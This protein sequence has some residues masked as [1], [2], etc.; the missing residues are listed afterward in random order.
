MRGGGARA[1]T[2][3]APRSP[4][5]CRAVR[6]GRRDI[7]EGP[8]LDIQFIRSQPD[9]VRGAIKNKGFDL[10]LDALL[11]IDKQRRET[12]TLLEQ[13]RARKNELSSVIP[14]AGKDERPKLVEEA[15]QI[16]TD[17]EE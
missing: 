12:M 6:S 2:G 16:R 11:A 8:M 9:L 13:R 10:D 5:R 4:R 15:K 1:P 7:G 14:K 17:I 3:C